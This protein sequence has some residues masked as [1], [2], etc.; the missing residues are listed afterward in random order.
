MKPAIFGFAF[1]G[2]MTAAQFRDIEEFNGFHV[3]SPQGQDEPSEIAQLLCT[4][5]WPLDSI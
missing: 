3:K 5:P 2:S 1:F 4:K